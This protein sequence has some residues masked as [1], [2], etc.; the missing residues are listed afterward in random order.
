MTMPPLPP[1]LELAL[2]LLLPVPPLE[3]PLEPPPL[4][5]PLPPLPPLDPVP[6]S[7]LAFPP[8]EPLLP[9][10][11]IATM[12]A[13]ARMTATW[14]AR[15]AFIVLPMPESLALSGLLRDVGLLSL[16]AGDTVVFL[17]HARLARIAGAHGFATRAD[18]LV[19]C[20]GEA[21][22]A[23]EDG[24]ALRPTWSRPGVGH[25]AG[26]AAYLGTLLHAAGM[27][28]SALPALL[29]VLWDEHRTFNLWSLVPPGLAPA[30]GRARAAGVKVAIVSNSEGELDALLVRVGL[31]DSIDVVVDSG[32]VGVE[33]PDPRIFRFAL[34]RTGVSAARALH[35]GD[36]A[37]TDV[38]GG[39]AAG[40]RVA[41]VD[42]FEHLKGR[43]P[44]VPRVPGAAEVADALASRGR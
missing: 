38:V 33:K 37:A 35:L 39:R 6:P 17:D 1:P 25:T 12:P 16:D 31:R 30:L 41:L 27:A 3:P 19:R 29:D 2:P 21:K 13:A 5:P 28:E 11:G 15:R 32:I 8:P 18:A 36:I 26:W 20:E 10:P 24:R 22:I 34:E 23:L 44:D 4:P 40:L 9:Q 42:P 43:H 14:N 7:P